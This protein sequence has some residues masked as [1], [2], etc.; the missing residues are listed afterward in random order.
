MPNPGGQLH[1]FLLF[2]EHACFCKYFM[3]IFEQACPRYRPA[4]EP[5]FC[6]SYP[7][8]FLEENSN[9]KGFHATIFYEKGG[10]RHQTFT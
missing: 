2:S 1:S 8:Y 9:A 5:E 10:A 3:F 7:I 6:K 4:R